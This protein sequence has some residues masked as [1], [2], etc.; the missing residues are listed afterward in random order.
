MASMQVPMNE[1]LEL[2]D[3]GKGEPTII[4]TALKFFMALG[5]DVAFKL[6]GMEMS[7][8]RGVEG[9]P[10]DPMTRAFIGRALKYADKSKKALDEM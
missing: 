9:C 8:V 6:V 1:F 2:V 10:K 3:A 4:K 5:A 7:D